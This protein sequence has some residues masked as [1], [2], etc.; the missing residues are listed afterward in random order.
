[1]SNQT[2]DR[3]TIVDKY[4][5]NDILRV[6]SIEDILNKDYMLTTS[7]NP[8]N[9]LVNFDE[10]YNYDVNV[11]GYNTLSYQARIIDVYNEQGEYPFNELTVHEAIWSILVN[12]IISLGDLKVHY[13]LVDKDYNIYSYK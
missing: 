1:M 13:C 2:L 11:L 5:K 3:V 4:N 10:W 12:D 7:D 6:K 8:W 9:P